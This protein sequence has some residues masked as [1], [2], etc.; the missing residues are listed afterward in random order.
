MTGKGVYIHNGSMKKDMAAALI[1]KNKKLL[2]VHN[3][4]HDGLRIEPPGGKKEPDEG[5]TEAVIRELEE[6]LGLKVIP[7]RLFGIFD[8][9]SPEGEFTVRM[10]ICDIVSGEPRVLE[11]EKISGFGWY[12]FD[13]LQKL[14]EDGTLV[15]NMT[16]AL[17]GIRKYL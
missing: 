2:L 9:H 1:V 12:G 10:Y 16:A 3:I 17:E 13:E 7:S 14:K 11:P 5:W 15:P 4:K 6:E 8:T